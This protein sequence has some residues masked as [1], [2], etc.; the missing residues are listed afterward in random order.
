MPFIG[1]Q[2]A[3]AATLLVAGRSAITSVEL[4]GGSIT[5]TTRSGTV[6]VG[7]V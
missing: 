7:V 6:S 3:V 2:P 1:E 4:I 5:V